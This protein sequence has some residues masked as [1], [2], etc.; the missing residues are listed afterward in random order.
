[1]PIL[2]ITRISKILP[3]VLSFGS[4]ILVNNLNGFYFFHIL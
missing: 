1:M 4:Q 2:G 3:N